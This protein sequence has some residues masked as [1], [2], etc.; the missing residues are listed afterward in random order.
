MADIEVA[1]AAEKVKYLLSLRYP[2]NEDPTIPGT[3]KRVS[4]RVAEVCDN[5]AIS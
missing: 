2:K 4:K 1:V 5:N 3:L